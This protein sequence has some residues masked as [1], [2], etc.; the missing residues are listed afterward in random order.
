ME[1]G[2]G[3]GADVESSLGRSRPV[4]VS[5]KTTAK[6]INC[7]SLIDAECKAK[8]FGCANGSTSVL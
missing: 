2:V 4:T 7:V 5:L 8:G 6:L 1:F 3:P